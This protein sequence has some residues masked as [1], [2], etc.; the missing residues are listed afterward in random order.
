MRRADARCLCLLPMALLVSL[1]PLGCEA[2]ST[3]DAR[4]VVD[5]AKRRAKQGAEQAREG[6]GEASRQAGAAAREGV[7]QAREGIA[8]ARERY[9]VDA[10]IDDTRR[11]LGQGL[12]EAAESFAA[13]TEA[14]KAHAS[15]LGDKLGDK[16]GQAGQV[17]L[18]VAPGAIE[19]DDDSRSRV[20]RVDPELVA[21]L[22]AEPKLLAREVSLRPKRGSTGSGLQ[23]VWARA[24]SLT[25]MLG[26]REGD[27]LLEINGAE[28]GTFEAIRALDEAL[29]GQPEVKLVYER[30]GKREELT[31]VQQTN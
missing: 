12:D 19:C 31:V 5:D 18:E 13:L 22:A 1:A 15:E 20:C 10:Q 24:E 21:E 11:R 8:D 2:R 28:L 9:E 16:L 17:G 23:L 3:A 27:I 30:E 4:E 7:A 14:G 6:M 26:L 29:S 25:A